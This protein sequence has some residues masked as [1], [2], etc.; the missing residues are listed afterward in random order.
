MFLQQTLS[1]GYPRLLRL[2][3][4]FFAKIAVL[5]IQLTYTLIKG[6]LVS[7]HHIICLN[8]Y[9][10]QRTV[11]VLRALSNFESLYLTRSSTKLN[12]S[13]S[14]GILWWDTDSTRN[15]RGH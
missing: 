8:L 14:Q 7:F 10:V 9:S 6:P 1:T 13:V 15:D 12:E 11:I 3:H 5:Q 4:E 2:F